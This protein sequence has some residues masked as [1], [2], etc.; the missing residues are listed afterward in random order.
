M[1][2]LPQQPPPPP[3]GAGANTMQKYMQVFC[4]AAVRA[5][6]ACAPK[7]AFPAHQ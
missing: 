3:Y 5:A 7:H 1:S 6:R 4:T 2:N